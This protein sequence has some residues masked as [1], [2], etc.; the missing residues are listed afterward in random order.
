MYISN[1]LF[2]YCTSVQ[3]RTFEENTCNLKVDKDRNK[4]SEANWGRVRPIRDGIACYPSQASLLGL[5]FNCLAP[6]T[7]N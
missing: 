1:N 7:R 4:A 2:L 3:C 5:S 6:D